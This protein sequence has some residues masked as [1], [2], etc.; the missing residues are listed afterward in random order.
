MSVPRARAQIGEE[1]DDEQAA[2][3][4]AV[5]E[6]DAEAADEAEPAIEDDEDPPRDGNDD[7]DA[8][9]DAGDADDA[10]GDGAE[11]DTGD[12]AMAEAGVDDAGGADELLSD[13]E[14]AEMDGEPGDDEAPAADDEGATA[15]SDLKRTAVDDEDAFETSR[16][17][18]RR[19]PSW[20][21]TRNPNIFATTNVTL[22]RMTTALEQIPETPRAA[23]S[24]RES[25]ARSAAHARAR[26][27]YQLARTQAPLSF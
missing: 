9:R 13:D 23:T 12:A 15:G 7:E 5:E 8:E 21:L 19:A 4:A 17:A 22:R 3:E 2:A 10:D 6:M 14:G 16:A 20:S 27:R 26:R 24:R 18:S 25:V 1:E 11:A